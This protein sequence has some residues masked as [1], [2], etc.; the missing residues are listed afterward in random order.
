MS[1]HTKQFERILLIKPSAL[2]DVVHTLP[3]LVK[4]RARYPGARIDWLVTPENAELICRHPALTNVV[5]FPR[6]ELARFGRNWSATAGL[7]QLLYEVWK[8]RYDLVIDLHGQARSALFTLATR[9]KTRIGFETAREGAWAAYS[10]RI[11]VPCREVHAVDRYLSLGAMLGFDDRPP[12]FSIHLAA[13]VSANVDRLLTPHGLLARPLAVLV[14][15][16]VWETKHWHAQGFA[17]VAQHLLASGAA[18]VLAG[19]PSDHERCRAVAALCPQACNLCGQTK[20]GD[21]VELLRRAIS[22]VTNDSGS[23]HLA[24]ALGKPVVS[25]FGPTNPVRTGPYARPQA[26]V[27]A[28]VPCSPCYLRKQ[29]HCRHAHICMT[30][31]TPAMVIERMEALRAAA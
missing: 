9:C 11:P 17:Q 22:C 3:V 13:E 30:E 10:H 2:G 14:P 24:V 19:A 4:L 27:R 15:G 6:R 16:T 26:V 7:I 1:I 25:V 18:V 20:L 8:T 31:V 23:M 29:R 28:D 5:P 21:L 12:D